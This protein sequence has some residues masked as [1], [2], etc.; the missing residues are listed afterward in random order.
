MKYVFKIVKLKTRLFVV[1][2]KW[3]KTF[4]NFKIL[5][6]PYPKNLDDKI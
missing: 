2:K 5:K 3:N 4:Y 1:F 6:K